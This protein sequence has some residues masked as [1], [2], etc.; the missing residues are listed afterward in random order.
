MGPEATTKQTDAV[1][2]LDPLA[3]QDVGLAPRDVLDVPG[4]DEHDLEAAILENLED[5]D[6]VQASSQSASRCR[7]PVKVLN[8]RT[9]SSSLSGGTATK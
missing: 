1:Q 6:P 9:G 7:S 3:V 2:L 8:E 5:R 4:V